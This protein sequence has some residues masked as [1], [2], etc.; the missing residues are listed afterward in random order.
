MICYTERMINW[1]SAQLSLEFS[2]NKEAYWDWE[3][4]AG[5]VALWMLLQVDLHVLLFFFH[6][7]LIILENV[8]NKEFSS[9]IHIDILLKC[10]QNHK[11]PLK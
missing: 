2:L 3:S 10:K 4:A 6:W 9:F 7:F 8:L 11:T 1:S 5:R